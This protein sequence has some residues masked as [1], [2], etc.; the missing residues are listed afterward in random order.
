MSMLQTVSNNQ[1]VVTFS[2]DQADLIKRTVAKDATN[3]ELQM[4]L[5]LA[6][7]YGLDPFRKEI[8]FWKQGGRPTI[9]TS[10]DG[11][12][13]IAQSDPNYDG[14]IG[15]VVKEG[16]TF[17]FMPSDC[18]VKHSF[19]AKRGVILGAWAIAFHKSRKPV[20]CFVEFKEY[21]QPNKDV[22]Q[23]YPS[24]MIQKVAEA[25][26]LKRQFAISGLVTQE[27]IGSPEYEPTQTDYMDTLVKAEP[28]VTVEE[29]TK[30]H[31]KTARQLNAIR[32]ALGKT[33]EEFKAGLSTML[34]TTINSLHDLAKQP[35]EMLDKLIKTL[36]KV[37]ADK[38]AQTE[39][40][41]AGDGQDIANQVLAGMEE[42]K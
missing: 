16:D 5:Y 33:E 34:K 24:A 35:P 21:N 6:G 1:P 7:Q 30:L 15:G 29:E 25:F 37:V 8:W 40:T 26:V 22:W 9:M 39:Q 10:R 2:K 38:K 3:D 41:A 14:L 28:P 23:K 42:V 13:K 19:A 18:T 20:A 17:E 27:E 11:Y 32:T 12:L 31:T 36:D 4:F